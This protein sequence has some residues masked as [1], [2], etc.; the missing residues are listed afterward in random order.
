MDEKLL[1]RTKV[2]YQLIDHLSDLQ[3]YFDGIGDLTQVARLKCTMELQTIQCRRDL[4]E[5]YDIYCRA[6]SKDC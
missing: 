2:Y 3:E 6:S 4:G 1:S 5:W